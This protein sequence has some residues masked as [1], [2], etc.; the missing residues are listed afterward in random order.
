MKNYRENKTI[1]LI[2]QAIFFSLL[3]LSCS[4]N[5]DKTYEYDRPV[6]TNDGIEVG[7]AAEVNIDMT[8][9][10]KA[11]NKIHNGRYGEVHSLLIFKDEK[12]VMEEYFKGHEYQ[13]D[14]P[15][16]YGELVE[17]NMDSIHCVHSVSKSITSLCVGIAI[18]KG[19]IKSVHQSIFDYLPDY[20]YLKTEGK[21]NITIEHLITMTSG[22]QWAE[23]NA[24]LSSMEN[25][26]VSIWFYEK[27][28]IDFVLERPLIAEP[29]THF[30]YSGG[31]IEILGVILENATGMALDEF[32]E[33]FLFEP[34]GIS[35]SDWYM[36]YPSGEIH[37]AGGLKLR[38]R[39]MVKIGAAILNKGIWNEE[40]IISEEWVEKCEY[41]FHGNQGITIPGE[42]LRKFGYSYTWW[43]KHIP[44]KDK[45]IN[46]YTANGWGGQKIIV[47]PEVNSVIAFTGANYTLKVKQYRIF[48]DYILPAF[49]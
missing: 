47:L 10:N 8:L 14:A 11:I 41:P 2:R 48:K 13:W 1:I 26:Q 38:P 7:T 22:L 28:P 20:Q 6:K 49:E 39:D 16:H 5:N 34:M 19:F 27:G 23:W 17:W 46:W 37:A 21:E 24:P 3:L 40:R 15:Y 30:N 44:Y 18:D 31:N 4:N 32:S 45:Q 25:D 36:R 42:D 43:T 9:I 33:K 35:S 12:L 29:G